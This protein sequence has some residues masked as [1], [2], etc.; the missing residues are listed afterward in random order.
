VFFNKYV[1]LYEVGTTRIVII[2]FIARILI[3]YFFIYKPINHLNMKKIFAFLV[4]GII[5]LQLTTSAQTKITSVHFF[6]LKDAKEVKSNIESTKSVNALIKEIGYPNNFYTFS[7]VKDDDKS[8]NYRYCTIGHWVSEEA[9][10]AIH[11]NAKFKAWSEAENKKAGGKAREELYR[12]FYSI[13][14]K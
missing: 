1:P 6:D 9:Y 8:T 13:D 7:K 4:L 10:K 3:N 14:L 12:R 11:E 5:G 2:T